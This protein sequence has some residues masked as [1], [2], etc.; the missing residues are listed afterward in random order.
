MFLASKGASYITGTTLA[1]DE[2]ISSAYISPRGDIDPFGGPPFCPQLE[3]VAQMIVRDNKY[4]LYL[5]KCVRVCAR[6]LCLFKFYV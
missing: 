5:C 4:I 1:V 3:K 6:R 2:G